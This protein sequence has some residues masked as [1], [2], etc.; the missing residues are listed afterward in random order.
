M[1]YWLGAMLVLS[2]ACTTR[3]LAYVED[4]GTNNV[5][6]GAVVTGDMTLVGTPDLA[7]A[8]CTDGARS[9]TGNVTQV[10]KAGALVAD[11]TCPMDSKC[12]D[13][14][15]QAP[16]N[17]QGTTG[18]PC[19]V[20]IGSGPG[21]SENQCTQGGGSQNSCQPF[22]TTANGD[23][24]WVCGRPVG[25]MGFPGTKCT[26]GSQCRSGFCGDNGFCFRACKDDFDCPQGGQIQFTCAD[27]SIVVDGKKVT[28]GSCV[29]Q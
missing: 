17:G 11:R 9:C 25:T 15:C 2:A 5:T 7:M 24:A 27:T 21:P 13:G 1:K 8:A 16:P 19:D 12:A 23:V 3:N 6:D 4:A 22:L 10:C 28:A 20:D 29:P 18:K 26:S 14:L